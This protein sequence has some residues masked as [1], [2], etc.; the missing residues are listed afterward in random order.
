MQIS[1]MCELQKYNHTAHL[2]Q[3]PA[4]PQKQIPVEHLCSWIGFGPDISGGQQ[5]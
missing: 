1:A 4:F 3:V 2:P 5:I